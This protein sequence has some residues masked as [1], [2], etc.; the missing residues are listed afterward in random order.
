[1]STININNGPVISDRHQNPLAG[2]KGT[3]VKRENFTAYAVL[4][5]ISTILFLILVFV[6]WTEW[7]LIK[8]S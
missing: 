8:L 4:A 3:P 7:S 6:L 2:G 1:M 5:I